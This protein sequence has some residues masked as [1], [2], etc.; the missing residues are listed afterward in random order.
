MTRD[1]KA[2]REERKMILEMIDNSWRLAEQLGEHEL[3]RGCNCIS[4]VNRRKRI[5]EEQEG[6]WKFRL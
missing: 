1:Q 3:K 5:L 2:I 6:E 4:C